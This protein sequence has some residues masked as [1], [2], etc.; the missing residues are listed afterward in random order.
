MRSSVQVQILKMMMGKEKTS[1]MPSYFDIKQ[2][3]AD[4]V[5]SKL[6]AM[7]P[8]V[9]HSLISDLYQVLHAGSFRVDDFYNVKT[10]LTM[11]RGLLQSSEL[12]GQLEN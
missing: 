5:Y 4:E 12:Y 11:L 7:K 1:K 6:V 9:V 8:E 3:E 10:T 2:M